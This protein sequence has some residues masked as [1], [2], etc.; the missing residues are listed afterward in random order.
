M[1]HYWRINLAAHLLVGTFIVVSVLVFGIGALVK[2]IEKGE[3]KNPQH[4]F[5]GIFL[6]VFMIVHVAIAIIMRFL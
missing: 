6:L 4:M 1:K 3:S 2:V 5:L